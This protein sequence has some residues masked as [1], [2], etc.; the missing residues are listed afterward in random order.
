MSDA[1]VLIGN[2]P[3]RAAVADIDRGRRCEGARPCVGDW[4]CYE[5]AG[6]IPSVPVLQR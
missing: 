2:L 3:S 5:G 4:P 1:V 6:N